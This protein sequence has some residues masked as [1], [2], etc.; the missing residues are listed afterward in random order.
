MRILL[1]EDNQT[2]AHNIQQY[3]EFEAITV[4]IT[5]DGEQGIQ[6]YN[7]HYYD[8]I[9]L[10]RMLP[11]MSGPQLC[12]TIRKSSDIPII[13][14]TARWTIDDKLTW[15]ECGADDYLVKPFDLA[16][17]VARV[18]ALHRR[19][20]T[21]DEFIYDDITISLVNRI[22]T[23]AGTEVKLTIKEFYI[24]EYLVKNR[25]T[26]V[27]RADLVEY[28]WWWDAVWENSG[29]LDVYISNLRKK[30]SREMIQTIKGFG[31]RI[32]R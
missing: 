32:E 15:F 21:S 22:A 25:G 20:T 11:H 3:C 26:P 1:V 30:L 10:D 27:S 28:V 16:E 18:Q 14:L 13:M 29:K 19:S 17:L 12:E 6:M 9:I 23:K 5:A 31:Y 2:I 4:D 7:T 24:L 8:L